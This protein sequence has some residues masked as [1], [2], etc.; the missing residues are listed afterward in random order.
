MGVFEPQGC[1][2]IT[3]CHGTATVALPNLREPALLGMMVPMS[4][5][6]GGGLQQQKGPDLPVRGSNL[7]FGAHWGAR[8]SVLRPPNC[9]PERLND[10]LRGTQLER[11]R[12]SVRTWHTQA[13]GQAP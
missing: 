2:G 8:A 1:Y 7:A 10:R 6:P 5:A 12:G 11:G 13:E 3:V 4:T 9:C